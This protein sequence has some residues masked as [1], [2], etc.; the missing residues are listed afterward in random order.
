MLERLACAIEPLLDMPPPELDL[1][2][3]NPLAVKSSK[4]LINKM[5]HMAQ[6]AK[7]LMQLKSGFSFSFTF[8]LR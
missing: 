1:S 5:S 3:F 4:H 7:M 2:T 8:P 6:Y